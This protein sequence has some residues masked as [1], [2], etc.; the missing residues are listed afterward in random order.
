M[1]GIYGIYR[2]D[3]APVDPL[4]LERMKTAMAYYGP[5]G[6]DCKVED[7]VGLGHLL[8]EVNPEDAFEKQPVRGERGLVVS[9]ARLDNRDALLE[10]FDISF[11]EAAQ[12]TDGKLVSLA[13]DRWGEKLC[14]HLQGDWALA[15]WDE[16]E[17]RLLLARDACGNATLYYY[18]GKGFIAFAS[19]LKALLALPGVAKEP[20]RLRLAEVLVSWQHDAELTAYK[21]FRRLLWAHAMSIGP[22]GQAR[23]WRHWSPESR[24]LLNWRR[25]EEYVEAFLEHYTRAVQSCL[26]TKKSVSAELSGGRDSGSVVAMA[27]QFLAGQGRGLTAYTSVPCLPP[28]G[29]SEWELGNEWEMAHATAEMAGANVLHIPIDAANYGVIQGIEH[30]LEVH[31]G[32]CHG[33]INHYWLQAIMETAY[34]NGAGVVLN[35]QR[36]NAT[37]SWDGNGSALLSLLQ[38]HRATALRLFLHAEPNLW[39]TMKRQ[40]LKPLLTPGLQA[41]RRLKTPFS[42]H[43]QAYSAL[44]IKMA[45]ELDLDGRMKTE[46]YDPSFTFSPL[47]D[48]HLLF[49][50]PAVG[51]GPGLG[52][53]LGAR[54]SLC[55]L[56]PTADL[57]LTEFLL[58]V[59]NDQ[60]CRRGQR[61]FLMKRAFRNRIPNPVLM[62]QRRGRQASDVGHRI[63][64]ELPAFRECL[65]S[66][67]SLP[68]ARD[69]LDIPLLHRCLED[70]VAKVDPGTTERA[71]TTL[72]R[73]LGV[74][75]FLRRLADSRS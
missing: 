74:G 18:E 7:R 23:T 63:L 72:L 25:D 38:G 56:D 8:L 40:V 58:R 34:R 69:I 29:A 73:G 43:W 22:D 1:S 35:G 28:D 60:F 47:E 19:S 26:R 10:A 66:L 11:A 65:N 5:D 59:P 15:G 21:G 70:I 50:L 36:G 55:Y 3:V 17:R 31:D 2:Y 4:W 52:A 64:R 42:E 45:K 62:A 75:L 14:S 27:A 20:D 9:A 67:D 53:E 37:V 6:G 33:A 61:S 13:F 39:L 32:P 12:T 16:R 44:N 46:G 54:H 30:F 41:L 51:I 48:V 71:D 24:E 68:E 49:F 57:S